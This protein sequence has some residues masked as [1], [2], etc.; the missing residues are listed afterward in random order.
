[1]LFG[2]RGVERIDM[3]DAAISEQHPERFAYF[4]FDLLYLDGHDLQRCP[5]ED[6]KAL[7]KDVIGAA[8]SARLLYIDHVIGQG[9]ALFD[10]VR[11]A[12]A[13]GIVSKR[14]GGA[15]RGRS[16]HDWL[17]T[18]VSETG[19][20]VVTGFSE[21]GPGRLDAVYVAELRGGRLVPAGGVRF[22]LGKGLWRRL[23]PLRDGPPRP[24]G[25][26]PVRP[27][28][29]VAIQVLWP[30]RRRLPARWRAADGA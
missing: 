3:C 30:D 9:P 29:V 11:Q 20:F 4:A 12:G 1:V 2:D 5:L 8:N 18:K 19:Q 6:R 27:E 10:V 14:R 23:D 17:K 13:E 28:L 21:L 16:R 24:Q 15:Y 26:V 22:G 7:L 25:I